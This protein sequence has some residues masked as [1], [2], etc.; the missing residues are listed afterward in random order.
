MVIFL[1]NILK[2]PI[3]TIRLTGNPLGLAP[4]KPFYLMDLNHSSST[5]AVG[6]VTI[7]SG[8][9]AIISYLLIAAGF[10]FHFEI[11]SQPSLI[12]ESEG[13][14]PLLLKWSMLADI[15]GYYLLLLPLLFY[16]YLNGLRHTLWGRISMTCGFG[17]IFIG[18]VG[19]TVLTVFW[20]AQI[21]EFPSLSITQQEITRKLFSS[22]TAI[23]VDGLWNL[24][25]T[26]LSGVWFLGI[27]IYFKNAQSK[28]MAWL[29]LALSVVCFLDFL[30]NAL[31]IKTL[32]DMALNIYLPFAPIW[33]IIVGIHILRRKQVI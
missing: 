6:F 14:R 31:S 10:N 4:N 8:F 22:I 23:V 3:F 21:N 7:L 2:C 20:P 13:I 12:F 29:T 5:S 15:F 24:L 32:A 17:Y 30:G 27:G 19:A 9:I 33:A 28:I 1:Q 11:F 16:I 18:S 25:D 26:F